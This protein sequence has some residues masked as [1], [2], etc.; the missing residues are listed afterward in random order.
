MQT[1]DHVDK[2][3]AAVSK[4]LKTFLYNVICDTPYYRE[5]QMQTMLI[6]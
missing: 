4:L 2:E 1:W 3:Y 6:T 5:Y